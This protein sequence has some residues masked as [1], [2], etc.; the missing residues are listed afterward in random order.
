MAVIA[1]L[2]A[3]VEAPPRAVA[4]PNA[5]L[6]YLDTLKV[7]LTGLVIAH[8]AGQAYGPTGGRWPI[9]EPERAAILGAFFSVNAAFFMGLFFLISAYLLPMSFDRKGAS[10]FLKDRFVRLGIPLAVAYGTFTA[11]EHQPDVAH[12]WFVGH[13][14]IYALIYACWRALNWPALR[15][16][17]P[18]HRQIAAYAVALGLVTFVVRIAFPIDQWVSIFG[19]VNSELAHL[20]QYASLFALGVVASR[21]RWLEGIPTPVGMRWLTVGI[22]LALLRYVLPWW[23]GGGFNAE[24]LLWSTWE[25]FICVGLCVGLP[26]LFRERFAAPGQ[27]MRRAARNAFGAYVLHIVPVVVGLQFALVGVPLDP[28][29][30]FLLVTLLGVPLSFLLAA[31]VRRAGWRTL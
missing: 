26:V 28:F 10:A 27:L 30:K 4:V 2:V 15:L 20:P 1:D 31:A 21:G 5:R 6:N 11:L 19:L 23:S 7:L 12:L 13:L 3:V 9:F 29:S 16:D 24:S 8:H 22:V 17:A 25:A 18:S 14:L